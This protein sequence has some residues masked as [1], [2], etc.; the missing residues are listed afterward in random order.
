MRKLRLGAILALASA[1]MLVGCQPAQVR[2]AAD[3]PSQQVAY[4]PALGQETLVHDG[5]VYQTVGEPME[6]DESDLVAIGTSEGYVLYQLPGGGA[7]EAGRNLLF[8]KTKD[9]RFQALQAIGTAPGQPPQQQDQQQ[10]QQPSPEEGMP[11]DMP[12]DMPE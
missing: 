9:G 2:Q 10:Q 5:L 1:T 3:E 4:D 8:I 11:G 6:G 7:G 12:Q